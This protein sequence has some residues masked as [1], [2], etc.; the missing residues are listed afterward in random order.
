MKILSPDT[1]KKTEQ[2]HLELLRKAPLHRRLKMVNSL[3]QATRMLSW[4]GICDRFPEDTH[5]FRVRFFV[6]LLYGDEYLANHIKAI[7]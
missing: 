1:S 7:E 4:Q 5:E 6:S 2:F 3:V